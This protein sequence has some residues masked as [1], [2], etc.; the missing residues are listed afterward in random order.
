[1]CGRLNVH[2]AR[3]RFN[4]YIYML[5]SL[6][7]VG[8][9]KPGMGCVL[10]FSVN[11]ALC[12]HFEIA[13][14][15]PPSKFIKTARFAYMLDGLTCV[16]F[17]YVHLTGE[18]RNQS[19]FGSLWFFRRLNVSRVWT[20]SASSDAVVLC[21]VHVCEPFKKWQRPSTFRFGCVKD[22]HKANRHEFIQV[23]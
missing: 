15:K 7:V 19:S 2:F 12:A 11:R 1:M 3:Q 10:C 6:V 18:K 14:T 4:I 20:R 16:V 21:I 13:G 8:A 22:I 9:P 5:A 23:K 17:I